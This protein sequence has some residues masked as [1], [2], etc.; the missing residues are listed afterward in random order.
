M[1]KK[2][3]KF[4]YIQGRYTDSKNPIGEPDYIFEVYVCRETNDIYEIKYGNN[5]I[6][7]GC[8][9]WNINGLPKVVPKDRVYG[10]HERN[11]NWFQRMWIYDYY[12]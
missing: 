4:G 6:T 3:L 11:L 10:I 2:N 1:W 9:V 12:K 8:K 7:G 5:K